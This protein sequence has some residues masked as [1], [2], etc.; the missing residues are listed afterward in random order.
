VNDGAETTQGQGKRILVID[1]DD[2]V[3]MLVRNMLERAGYEVASASD[4]DVGMQL[5]RQQPFDLVITDLYMPNKE[6]LET[7]VELKREFPH[8]QIIAISGGNPSAGMDYLEVAAKLGARK[9]LAK[10]IERETLLAS[11]GELLDTAPA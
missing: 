11:V 5:M 9:V 7:I 3:R 6:G 1:D 2:Q 8:A 4:G 10:P